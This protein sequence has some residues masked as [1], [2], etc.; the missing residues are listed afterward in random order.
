MIY[1]FFFKFQDT[2]RG[3]HAQV[4]STLHIY[5]KMGQVINIKQIGLVRCN[6]VKIH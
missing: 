3:C 2:E 6:T 5:W 1:N 4:L